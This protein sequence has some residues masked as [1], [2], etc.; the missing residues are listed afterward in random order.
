MLIL[1]IA[2]VAGLCSVNYEGMFCKIECLGYSI[3][4]NIV[5]M[6]FL[7]SIVIFL[8]IILA[9]IITYIVLRV[10]NI[11]VYF[12]H[13][14]IDSFITGSSYLCFGESHE[15]KRYVKK[16]KG[17]SNKF[18]IFKACLYFK[19][20]EY[21]EAEKYF[22]LAPQASL[23]KFL[24]LLLL[25]FVKKEKSKYCQLQLLKKLN[26]VFI[27][28]FWSVIFRIEI[29]CIEKKW[30]AAIVE[31][32]YAIKSHV[33]LPYDAA[34]M[35]AVVG[36]AAADQCY[37]NEKYREGLKILNDVESKCVKDLF[38]TILKA[39][40]YI[41]IDNKQKAINLLEHQYKV[42]A[43]KHV[44]ILYLEV[45]DDKNQA[46]D[47][48]Y[49]ISPNY[50]FSKYL[51]VQKSINLRQYNV[52]LQYLNDALNKY[53]YISFYLLMIKLR[54]NL[55]DDYKESLWCFENLKNAIPDLHWRC[56]VCNCSVSEWYYECSYCQAFDSIKWM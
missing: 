6:L 4:L 31:L 21:E 20:G 25:G 53:K 19:I 3:E 56:T 27:K 7:L 8:L 52:A 12:L 35:L 41:K 32:K 44:A 33:L 30:C 42:S 10:Y 14:E 23:N 28:Q 29:C 26:Q 5:V 18:N 37:R 43:H 36:Y 55:H 1:I 9:R 2:I 16:F 17:F 34:R 46:T 48:L 13:K 40:L 49:K 24:G 11:K 51:M 39:K 22:A 50:Y 38:I 45:S 15:V 47:I 54:L